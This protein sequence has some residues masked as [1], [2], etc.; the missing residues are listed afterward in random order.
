MR[1]WFKY[2]F[3]FVNLDEESLYLTNSGN[4]S[5]TKGLKEY[6]K[7]KKNNLPSKGAI[8]LALVIIAF[9]GIIVLNISKGKISILLLVGLPVTAYAVY[10]YMKSEVGDKYLIPFYKIKGIEVL[11]ESVVIHFMDLND[12]ESKCELKGVSTEGLKKLNLLDEKIECFK[13]NV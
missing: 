3:G 7:S 2:E 1:D 5:D 9:I 6:E 13:K 8:F 4:W 12:L 11:E 10:N